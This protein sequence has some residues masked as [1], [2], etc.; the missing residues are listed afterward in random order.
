MTRAVGGIIGGKVGSYGG[1]AAGEA[2]NDWIFGDSMALPE[3]VT[4]S[5][6]QGRN[7]ITQQAR[8]EAKSRGMSL[9]EYYKWLKEQPGYKGNAQKIKD[10]EKA[11]KFD[12]C[13][14]KQKRRDIYNCEGEV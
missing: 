9:C 7:Y 12:G 11:E 10:I 6:D 13:R 3:N 5:K 14:N 8:V 4:A 2:I 1:R